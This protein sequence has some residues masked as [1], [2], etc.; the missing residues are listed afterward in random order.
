M[1]VSAGIFYSSIVVAFVLAFGIGANDVA[2]SF[3]T[4]VGSGALTLQRAVLIAAVCEFSGAVTL[5]A[6]VSDTIVRQISR[7]DEAACW[8]CDAAG[9]PGMLLFMLGMACA[10]LSGALFMLLATFFAMPVSTT[11]AVVGAVLGMTVAGAG[12]ACVRWGYPGL[13]TIVAS[14]FASPLL[15]GLLSAAMH[16]AVQK[17]VFKAGNPFAVAMRILPILYGGSVGT[18]LSLVL[19][20]AQPTQAWPGWLTA[21]VTIATAVAVAIAVQLLL[22]PHLQRKISSWSKGDHM[23]LSDLPRQAM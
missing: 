23:A 3:G 1:P 22:A 6:G 12:G 8:N 20:K 17:G 19:L 9:S 4:S 7:L 14:W 16:L 18:V 5:G 21:L 13:L 2:N 11:H 15:A 10:L